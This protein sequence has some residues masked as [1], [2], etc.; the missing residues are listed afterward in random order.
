MASLKLESENQL[1]IKKLEKEAKERESLIEER[2]RALKDS[3]NRLRNVI[4]GAELGYWDWYYQTGVHEVNDRWLEMLGLT[5]SDIKNSVD[6]WAERIHPDDKERMTKIV[7]NAIKT[8]T[9]YV[10][11]FRMKHKN[12]EWTWIQGAGALIESDPVSGMPIR[13]C[14]THQDITVRKALEQELEFRARRDSLTGLYNRSEME[15]YFMKE[16]ERS[17]RY[18]RD[19]SMFLI[20]IDHFKKINDQHGHQTGDEILKQFATFLQGAVRTS[21]FVAR[22]GGEEFIV[23]LP[24][25][26]QQKAHELAERIRIKTTK[27]YLEMEQ[28]HHKITISLGIA[29]FPMHGE[30]YD[31]LVS[32]ADKAMYEAKQNGRN[33]VCLASL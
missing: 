28:I 21:D 31:E 15:K 12:G 9:P 19:L 6:D 20:D 17:S 32:I 3:E 10:A 1:L 16:L 33:Q 13:L 2:T 22:Y 24:E 30:N 14:G 26:T 11:D 7:Q 25:T 29:S 5:R 23:I 8:Q 18:N 4:S 27:L